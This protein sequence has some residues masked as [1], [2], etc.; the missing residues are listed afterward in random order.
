[1]YVIT[2]KQIAIVVA[3][4]VGIT[5]AAPAAAIEGQNSIAVSVAPVNPDFLAYQNAAG[6]TMLASSE[7]GGVRPPGPV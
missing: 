3:L 2:R 4:I 1:M 7:E 6:E 5:L